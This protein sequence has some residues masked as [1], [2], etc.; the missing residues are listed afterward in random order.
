MW[1]VMS[2]AYGD[3]PLGGW[4]AFGRGPPM[5]IAT[6]VIPM[7]ATHVASSGTVLLVMLALTMSSAPLSGFLRITRHG[8]TP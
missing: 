6:G 1:M 3:V 8:G 7:S 2:N 4:T 5:H